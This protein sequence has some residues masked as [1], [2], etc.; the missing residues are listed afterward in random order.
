[1]AVPPKIS[2]TQ[3]TVARWTLAAPHRLMTNGAHSGAACPLRLMRK[4]AINGCKLRAERHRDAA[5]QHARGMVSPFGVRYGPSTVLSCGSVVP[6]DSCRGCWVPKMPALC[7]KRSSLPLL[8]YGAPPSP[9]R[10]HDG[11]ENDEIRRLK[12]LQYGLD[13]GVSDQSLGDGLPA[14][15]SEVRSV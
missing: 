4:H 1:M 2:P 12:A 10:E 13:L 3:S 14:Y 6:P 11:R 15:L 7:Q 5:P 9:G 8:L